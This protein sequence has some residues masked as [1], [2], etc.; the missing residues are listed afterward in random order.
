MIENILTHLGLEPRRR[1]RRR[2]ASR[3]RITPAEP[4]LP[5][6]TRR[7]SRQGLLGTL[8]RAGAARRASPAVENELGIR[9]DP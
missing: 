8:S 2:R 1:P 9:V 3:C 4:H 5:S 6:D 7:H